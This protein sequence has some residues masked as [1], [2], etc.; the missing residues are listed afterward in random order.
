MKLMCYSGREENGWMDGW[1]ELDKLWSLIYPVKH[2]HV[3]M[4][5]YQSHLFVLFSN[6]QTFYVFCQI[7]VPN[8]YFLNC[9]V[10]LSS[11]NITK[12]R[13]DQ[14]KKNYV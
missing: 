7:N 6:N 8:F 1:M 2:K 5:N 9:L 10:I 3:Y 14:A 12:F 11:Y 13:I 4:P